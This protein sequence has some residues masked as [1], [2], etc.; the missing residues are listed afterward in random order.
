VAVPQHCAAVAESP[1]DA[2]RLDLIRTLEPTH[3]WFVARR[4]LIG[5]L[6]RHRRAPASTILDVGCGT[7]YLAESLARPGVRVVAM[8]L[9][10]RDLVRLR[11]GARVDAVVGSAT[12]LPVASGV[13]DVTLALDVL[14]HADDAAAMREMSR[15]LKP[16]GIAVVTVPALPWLWS[17][18][19]RDAGHL[20]RYTRRGLAALVR[21]AGLEAIDI[22]FHQCLLLPAFIVTRL[23]G[24]RWRQSQRVEERPARWLNGICL[25]ISRAEIA[26]G[27]YVRWPWGSSLAAVARKP[28]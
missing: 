18:R 4:A 25:A 8:D 3:F 19:D 12:A 1:F 21:G 11:A 15:V 14:E 26:A 17:S 6:L 22:R 9:H 13:A 28:A 2:S 27:D 7:G 23:A 24:R 16:G 5:R 20:R 10:R